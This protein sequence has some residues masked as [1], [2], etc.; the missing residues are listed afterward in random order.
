MTPSLSIPCHAFAHHN[1]GS[2]LL[3]LE[4]YAD[5]VAAFDAALR[6]QC[7]DRRILE[8]DGHGLRG[9][10]RITPRPC[11]ASSRLSSFAPP[12]PRL[13]ITSSI[14]LRW[15]KRFDEAVDS[16][17]KAA[18]ALDPAL[19]QAL[20]SRGSAFARL[21]RFEDAIA[22]Y[23]A[24]LTMR[25]GYPGAILNRGRRARG[26]GRCGVGRWR[27][28]PLARRLEPAL[29]DA[30]LQHGARSPARRR[31]CARALSSTKP[32]GTR[33]PGPRL[34][35]PRETLWTGAT[36]H[37]GQN[38]VASRRAGLRRRDPVLSFRR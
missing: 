28:S 6:H 8:P 17:N 15:L 18:L 38:A 11:S 36:A 16:A 25:P 32:D 20:N 19:Y 10:R 31:L 5:A 22:D 23:E 33:P 35:Y 29:P 27:I 12:M 34:A 9:P 3:K 26:A 24:A 4:A 2:A 37:S 21:N 14:A 1:R 13:S 30:E 7:G